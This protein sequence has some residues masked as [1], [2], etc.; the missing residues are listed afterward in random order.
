MLGYTMSWTVYCCLQ[1]NRNSAP[2]TFVHQYSEMSTQIIFKTL[3]RLARLLHYFY[4]KIHWGCWFTHLHMYRYQSRFVYRCALP[5]LRGIGQSSTRWS[6]F[7]PSFCH[8][9]ASH[10]SNNARDFWSLLSQTLLNT[11]LQRCE[12]W[13]EVELRV[14][15]VWTVSDV[16]N[17]S[18]DTTDK[19]RES[20]C[21]A[22]HHTVTLLRAVWQTIR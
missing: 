11:D 10:V 16:T 17:S 2:T 8:V 18:G 13:R 6:S 3:R 21:C 4:C 12:L 20:I 9:T 1:F 15:A 7:W 5:S 22:A 14:H 19:D